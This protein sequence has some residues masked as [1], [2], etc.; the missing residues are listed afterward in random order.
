MKPLSSAS[1]YWR[2]AILGMVTGLGQI[3]RHVRLTIEANM[4]G[5]PWWMSLLGYPLR[6]FLRWFM[7]PRLLRGNSP[8]GV[9]TAAMF[10]PPTGLNDT[11][12]V[13]A[14]AECVRRFLEYQGQLH[15]HPGFGK[16]D[17]DEFNRFHAAHAAH[18]LSFLG[19]V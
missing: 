6:P 15:P 2:R 11:A 7:L 18:H 3:C 14:F 12:E 13:E 4:S 16:L 1:N 9:K 10:V 8:S 19:I 5:Y 17:Q